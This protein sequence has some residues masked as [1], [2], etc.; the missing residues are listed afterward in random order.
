MLY[1]DREAVREAAQE[2]LA[3]L[4]ETRVVTQAQGET[5]GL[6]P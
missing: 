6:S 4:I 3:N 5:E 1:H 2:K